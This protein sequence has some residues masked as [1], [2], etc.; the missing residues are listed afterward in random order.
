[1]F[2]GFC[3]MER[4]WEK[5]DLFLRDVDIFVERITK[6]T[7]VYVKDQL[8]Q[9]RDKLADLH[10]KALVKINHS[11]M[12]LLCA[13]FLI[14]QGYTVDIEHAIE[15]NLTCDV[16][17]VKGDGDFIVEAE[18]GFVPPEHALDPVTYCKAR[19]ASKIS[20]YS[21]YATKFSIGTLPYYILYVPELFHKPPRFRNKEELQE[22][23]N[24]CDL[25]YTKPPVGLDEI[26]NARLHSIWI[27]NL[28]Q[29]TIKEIDPMTYAT[30]IVYWNY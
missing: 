18:T 5:D 29:A 7:N 2:L 11:I 19:I 16:Y 13:K 23:K 28:D 3:L 17:G 27:I 20:R 21:N 4:T 12:E 30:S 24:L 26:I 15:G 14:M 9:L 10:D 6:D 25:Y 22:V 8:S 1:M